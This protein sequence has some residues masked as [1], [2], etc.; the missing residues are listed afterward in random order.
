MS[1]ILEH[2]D[3]MEPGD[4]I[5]GNS[6]TNQALCRVRHCLNY[7]LKENYGIEDPEITNK[8]LKMH[9]LSKDHFDFINNLESLIEKGIADNSVDTNANKG[10]TSIEGL[11]AEVAM[12][13]KKLTGYR[14]L[15]RKMKDM[16]GKKRAKYLSGL[17]YNMSLALADSTNILKPYCWSINASKLV[18][19]G[20]P[21]GALPSLPPKRIESYLNCLQEVIHQLSNHLAGAIAIGSFFLDLAHMFIYRDGNTLTEIKQDL[22]LRKDIENNIQSFIHSMNHLSRNSVE[23]PFTNIS[24]M[25]P[26]KLRALIDDDNMGWY[27][28]KDDPM[29]GVPNRALEDCGDGD[30]KEY[31]INIILEL[32]DIY[33]SIM[34][35]GDKC[36]DGR[37]ITF[38]VSTVNIS[39]D[40]NRLNNF[41]LADKSFVDKVCKNHDIMRYNIYVSE[42]QKIASCCFSGDQVFTYFKEDGTPVIT[43][44]SDFAKDN[45]DTDKEGEAHLTDSKKYVFDPVTKE[46]KPITGVIR[47]KNNFRKLISIELEDGS[48]IK[49]TP[50]QKF[51][52]NNSN[53]MV[54]AQEILDSPDKYDI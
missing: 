21:W 45:L 19:E 4:P 32:E 13:I 20:R 27:F 38:P 1:E 22:E 43:T 31:I 54:T 37:P 8:F 24:I 2:D 12:P 11:F 42:G 34:D 3:Y 18:I 15:Y 52:D 40:S 14:Y 16:Y 26:I 49:A 28:E 44:F 39:R 41:I 6:S 25:D 33:M 30:W 50:N 51:W 53:S 36:H 46:L 23:S 47:M 48:I 35:A 17:M 29:D 5:F 10:E 7:S 9:G